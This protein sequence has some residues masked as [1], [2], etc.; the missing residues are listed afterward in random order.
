M[1]YEFRNNEL[2]VIPQEAEVVKTIF[3]D[4]LNG[5]GI[6]AIVRKLQDKNVPTKDGGKWRESTIKGILQNEKYIGNL[7]LQKTFVSDHITKKQ[8]KNI[9][10]LPMYFVESNHE[11]IIDIETFKKVQEEIKRRTKVYKFRENLKK[12]VFTGKIQCGICGKNYRRRIAGCGTKYEKATWLC[13]TFNNYGK[14]YCSSNIVPEEI[15]EKLSAE[16]LNIPKFDE[17]IFSDKV[18]KIIVPSKGKLKFIFSDGSEILKTW[19]YPS[20][21]ESWTEE[22]KQMARNRQNGRKTNEHSKESSDCNSG[23]A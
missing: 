9:G 14:K 10:Q 21:S 6:N 5:M 8:R 18:K 22:M 3:H 23:N 17:K 16:I 15:I 20:R 12:Y 13:A 19:C 1:G 2:K 4:Y 7:L 11:A